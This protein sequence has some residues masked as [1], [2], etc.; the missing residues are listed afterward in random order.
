MPKLAL[1][2]SVAAA[3]RRRL[4]E[5]ETATQALAAGSAFPIA[6]AGG[7]NWGVGQT[8][9]ARGVL[10][11]AVHIEAETVKNYRVW[12]PTDGY[13]ADASGLAALLVDRRFA[14]LGEARRGLDLAVLALDPCLPYE[15]ELNNA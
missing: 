11:H 6:A 14:D 9:T 15:V 7:G 10:T 4:A 5:V 13:F 1:P 12:A 2:P 3:F 8:L